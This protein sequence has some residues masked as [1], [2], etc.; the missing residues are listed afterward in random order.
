[1]SGLI[2]SCITCV[3][4][5]GDALLNGATSH[6]SNIRHIF[7]KSKVLCSYPRMSIMQCSMRN[8][9]SSLF[10]CI[11]DYLHILYMILMMLSCVLCMT[12]IAFIYVYYG[13]FACTNLVYVMMLFSTVF[14]FH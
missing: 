3:T 14:S 11:I 13:L 5:T 6:G 9:C 10:I 8:Q 4:R 7:F 1:M 2:L 12:L